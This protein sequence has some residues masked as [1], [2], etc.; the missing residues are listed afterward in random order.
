MSVRFSC[1]RLLSA[2]VVYALF[3]EGEKTISVIIENCR[4][5]GGFSQVLWRHGIHHGNLVRHIRGNLEAPT[6]SHCSLGSVRQE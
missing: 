1:I 5:E 4:M 3:L 2:F 6:S